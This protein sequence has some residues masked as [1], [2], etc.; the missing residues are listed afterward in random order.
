MTVYPRKDIP[1]TF[2]VGYHV[3]LTV[4]PPSCDCASGCRSDRTCL[5]IKAAQ[6]FHAGQPV[7]F[8]RER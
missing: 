8:W 7:Q 3:D 1:G 5:H 4:N 2:F 6:D